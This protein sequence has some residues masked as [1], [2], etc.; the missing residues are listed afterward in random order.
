MEHLETIV[1][2]PRQPELEP[3][4][5]PADSSAAI[6]IGRLGSKEVT[7][8]NFPFTEGPE[9]SVGLPAGPLD[10]IV[11]DLKPDNVLWIRLPE[12]EK[13]D[14]EINSDDGYLELL[15]GRLRIDKN[16]WEVTV[17]GVAHRIPKRE[18]EVLE[19]LARHKNMVLSSDQILNGVFD[20]YGVGN[21]VTVN[22]SSLRKK[23]GEAGDSIK[24]IR[25]IGY[26]LEDRKPSSLSEPEP[27]RQVGLVNA[28]REKDS[29]EKVMEFAGGRVVI[30]SLRRELVIDGVIQKTTTTEF[31]ILEVMAK[32]GGRVTTRKE[33]INELYGGFGSGRVVDVHLSQVRKRLGD[34][35]ELIKTVRGVGYLLRDTYQEATVDQPSSGSIE[36]SL[37]TDTEPVSEEVEETLGEF[38]MNILDG[39]IE[40]EKVKADLSQE[41]IKATELPPTIDAEIVTLLNALR[42][43]MNTSDIVYAIFHGKI[44]R[45]QFGHIRN[46]LEYMAQDGTIADMG[47]GYYATYGGDEDL[48]PEHSGPVLA[49]FEFPE[50]FS[51]QVLEM[52]GSNGGIHIGSIVREVFGKRLESREFSLVKSAVNN[53]CTEGRL[54]NL[55]GGNFR[56]AAPTTEGNHN[57][58]VPVSSQGDITAMLREAGIFSTQ[59]PSRRG[60]NRR[61]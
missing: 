27:Q 58:G 11:V 46:L 32:N 47:R 42:R 43:N 9:G 53:L 5:P 21:I 15:G 61:R 22:I 23:L 50:D 8:V 34:F 16:R 25:G 30:D 20:G 49:G 3:N 56:L 48:T 13:T 40:P 37:E 18:F 1:T 33:V 2:E 26:M 35:A 19:M 45:E 31:N 4:F 41:F 36:I 52:A 39:K 24:T 12:R 17:D 10:E 29:E 51:E 55:G 44:D 59:Q 57:D 7:K 54:M 60:R 14:K 6:F 38:V 28:D